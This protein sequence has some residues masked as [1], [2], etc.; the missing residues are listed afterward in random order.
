MKDKV[1]SFT[2]VRKQHT[3]SGIYGLAF[4][5]VSVA[6]L[7]F[8][9]GF[10]IYKA[11]KMSGLFCLIPYVTMVGSLV[12]MFVTKKD[13]RRTDV[14]GKYLYVGHRVCQVSVVMHGVI[15]LI[16]VLKIIL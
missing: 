12:G 2:K 16:G 1:Y 7:L 3:K 8:F 11:G 13:I 14:A 4:G 5:L 15:L 6:V 10:G 9:I